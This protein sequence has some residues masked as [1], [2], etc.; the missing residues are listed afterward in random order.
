[1]DNGNT[2]A[3]K[4]IGMTGGVGSGKSTALSY[5]K[6]FY[7]CEV[8][9]ADEIGLKLEEKGGECFR[10]LVELLSEDILGSN[11]EIDRAKMAALIFDDEELLKKVNEIVHPAVRKAVEKR[12]AEV[13]RMTPDKTIFLESAIFVEAGY[14][15]MLD[16]LW[17]ITS[18]PEVRKE[19]LKGSRGYTDEKCASIMD[20]QFSDAEYKAYADHILV[21]DGEKEKLFRQ[22]DELMTEPVFGLDIGTRSVVGTVGF[23]KGGL[24]HVCAQV[25]KEHDTRSM[26][27]GQ[28]HD[29]AKVAATIRD[30]KEELEAKTGTSLKRVCIAAAGRVLKTILIHEDLTFE[31]DIVIEGEEIYELQ[32]M[33]LE[34]AYRDFVGKENSDEK[35]YLVGHTVT[36]TYLNGNPIGNLENQKGHMIG[37]DLIATFLPEDVVEGLYRAVEM[38]GLEVANLTLEPI[39]ASIV[40]I[41]EKFRMLNIALVDVGAGTS[42][43]CITDDGAVTAYGMLPK[44]GDALTEIIAK[45]CLVEFNVAEEIKR[46]AG[47]EEEIS[48]EDILGIPNVIKAS[49]VREILDDELS[50]MTKEVAEL[51]IR[52]NGGKPVSAIFVVGGGGLVE[53][54]TEKLAEN[55]NIPVNRVALRG[56]EVLGRFVFED[57][58]VKH[59]S[60]MVTPLGICLNYYDQN[61]NFIYVTVNGERVKLYNNGNLRVSDAL[62]Q[63]AVP[64]EDIFPKRGRTIRFTVN[65]ETR[66]LKG[67]L[68][69]AAIITINEEVANIHSSVRKNDRVAILFSTRGTDAYCKISELSEYRKYVDEPIAILVNNHKETPAYDIQDGDIISI[70]PTF[71]IEGEWGEKEPHNEL[72]HE[73]VREPVVQK[74]VESI[75]TSFK[76][77]AVVVNG[78]VIF[79]KG[80]EKYIFVD[81]FD[82]IDFDL[83]SPKGRKIV[84]K[85]NGVSVANFMQELQENS[86]IEIYWED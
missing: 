14:L 69:D 46:K 84:T 47:K 55:M 1:M 22:I 30:V 7:G 86:I 56:E 27:D 62:M 20:S 58:S 51:M 11:G 44:A 42:D 31:T 76:E 24:F 34:K 60:M 37:L 77:F 75:Q 13:R 59:D 73:A 8:L 6:E 12:V 48:Y 32:S 78:D 81:V 28:I 18:N 21:N 41:P 74:K 4:L 64:N 67:T 40:A 9:L 26:M 79:M 72:S 19:R 54:Y 43:I 65:G 83:K 53:G 80:K 71:E 45:H 33:A 29:V 36:K 10:P 66:L 3:G 49:K 52:L 57:D 63:M 5:L 61:N 23:L 17:V 25:V 50:E 35:F 2:K 39:A 38:A 16:E 15:D 70:A 68:G 85:V 82:Y